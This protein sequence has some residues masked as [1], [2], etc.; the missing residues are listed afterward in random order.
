MYAGR[1]I[2]QQKRVSDLVQLVQ[3]LKTAQTNFRL[4]IVGDG[5]DTLNLSKALRAIGEDIDQRVTFLGNVPLPSA[6]TLAN[7]RCVCFGV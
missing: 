6:K 7:S 5:P 4:R 3:N 1:I 2:E